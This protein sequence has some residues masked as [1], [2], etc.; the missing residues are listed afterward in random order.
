[1]ELQKLKLISFQQTINITN[2]NKNIFVTS[3]ELMASAPLPKNLESF[4]QTKCL[5]ITF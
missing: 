3:K 4:Q 5:F 1:M 2:L